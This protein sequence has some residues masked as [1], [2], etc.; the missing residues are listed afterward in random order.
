MA[1]RLPRFRILGLAILAMALPAC[2]HRAAR[3]AR[4]P[5][6]V[7]TA[8]VDRPEQSFGVHENLTTDDLSEATNGSEATTKRAVPSF[9][10][11]RSAADFEYLSAREGQPTTPEFGPSDW[12]FEA[13]SER[14]AFWFPCKEACCTVAR[15]VW[16]DHKQF[17]SCAN[18]TALGLGIAIAAPL[19]NTSADRAFQAWY[20]QSLGSPGLDD[21]AFVAK[22][23]GY[24]TYCIPAY[25]GAMGIGWALAETRPGTWV[26]E[27]GQRS[28]RA[29]I[30]GGPPVGAL[31]YGLGASRP[32]EYSSRWQPFRDNNAVAGHGFVGA[33]PFLTAATMCENRLARYS[34]VACSFAA[35]W[36][37][38]HHDSHYLSQAILGWWIAYLAV[39][40][41]DE[42]QTRRGATF[43]IMPGGT[44]DG[45][46][47]SALLQF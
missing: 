41:V 25:F 29:L 22:Q 35:T 12:S 10:S 40:C 8:D 38:V 32:V 34:L 28:L 30:I 44:A 24:H 20:H 2:A 43:R 36:S 6:H 47:V 5:A 11:T 31:Q 1:D 45:P 15:V 16:E 18:L 26:G 4:C 13:S 7:P 23:P 21:F 19:A 42:V 14:R 37:R 3:V 9:E 17:Y 33:V 27:W 46:G 39:E